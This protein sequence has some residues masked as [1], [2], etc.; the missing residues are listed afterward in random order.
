MAVKR[1]E[2]NPL[3]R[4]FDVPPS[5]PDFEVVGAFNPGVIEY[6]GQILLLLRVAERPKNKSSDEQIAPILNTH[7]GQIEIFCVHNDDLNITDIPDTRTFFYK[8]RMY[9]TSISHFRLARSRDG[10]HF[11]VDPDPTIFP[12]MPYETYGLED[13]RITQI[14][15]T[16]YITYKAVSEHGICTALITTQDFENFTRHGIIFCPENL[17]VVLFPEKINGQFW[18]LTRPVPRNL[19][20]LGIWIASSPDGIHWAKHQPLLAPREECFDSARIGASCVPIHTERGW[21]EIYH[22]ADANNRYCL[23]SVLL[24]LNHPN[25]VLARS[26]LPLLEP[27]ADYEQHGF[28]GNVVFSCG[29]IKQ[30]GGS[31]LLYYGASDE[32]TAGAV[33]TIDDLYYSLEAD[34]Q[35]TSVCR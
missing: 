23:A 33:L 29:T 27:E 1:I 15:E 22:G 34:R 32:Y 10:I 28:F 16:F 30:A 13:P 12:A 2:A 20:P 5:R 9:L 24:D 8:D 11:E 4:P 21:I 3:I 7:T 19:G 35:D 25:Q 17:D 14:E 6:N 18:A 31:I 26:N